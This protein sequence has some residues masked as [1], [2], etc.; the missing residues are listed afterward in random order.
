MPVNIL[1]V[2][3]VDIPNRRTEQTTNFSRL[4]QP[5]QVLSESYSRWRVDDHGLLSKGFFLKLHQGTEP[6][7][8]K[9][10]VMV[11][12]EGPMAVKI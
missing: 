12:R 9:I 3:L 5:Q 4:F 6:V 2:V 11:G 1:L 10:F 8:L 7:S